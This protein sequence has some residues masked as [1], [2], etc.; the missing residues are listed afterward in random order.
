MDAK[1]FVCFHHKEI[2]LN[3]EGLCPIYVGNEEMNNSTIHRDNDG[4]NIHEKNPRYGELTA[5]YWIWKN[6]KGN[7]NIG[8][9]HYRRYFIDR[10]NNV[11]LPY[12][13][14]SKSLDVNKSQVRSALKKWNSDADIVLPKAVVLLNTV[15]TEFLK[16]HN[17]QDLISMRSILGELHPQY[18]PSW[19]KFMGGNTMHLF[20][21][22]ITTP[23]LFNSYCK[24]LF[25][26]LFRF[27]ELDRVARPNIYQG[28]IDGFLAERLLNV[29]VMHHALRVRQIPI[30]YIGDKNK[31]RI[32]LLKNIQDVIKNFLF[33]IIDMIKSK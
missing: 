5:L 18:L 15:E 23:I 25:E 30:V 24:W 16:Y 8:L 28:R 20:N 9:C 29:Y 21:M 14:N 6:Y 10:S 3:G 12:Q 27:D 11:Y 4:E 33:W 31:Y 17:G 26:L 2:P 13:W 32:I 22:F 19:D 7:E 1:I